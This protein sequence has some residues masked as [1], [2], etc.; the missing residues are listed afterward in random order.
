MGF[1]RRHWNAV[2]AVSADNANIGNE[3]AKR[4]MGETAIAAFPARPVVADVGV[5]GDVGT[6]GD[7]GSVGDDNSVGV[8]NPR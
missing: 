6:V 4:R 8:P 1:E 2:S 5:F 3:T 7:V